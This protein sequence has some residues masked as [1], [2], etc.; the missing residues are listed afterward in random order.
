MFNKLLGYL[1]GTI[2]EIMSNY[3]S[4]RQR[5]LYNQAQIRALERNYMDEDHYYSSSMS[6]WESSTSSESTSEEEVIARVESNALGTP[7]FASLEKRMKEK[8]L[9]EEEFFK[10]EEFD[11]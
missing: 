7:Y 9:K 3:S 1:G 6:S 2:S 4:M 11:I 10:K 5:E 8:G